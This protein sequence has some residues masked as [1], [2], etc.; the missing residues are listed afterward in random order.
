MK[1]EMAEMG[2]NV[3]IL[4][5]LVPEYNVSAPITFCV[6]LGLAVKHLQDR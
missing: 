6:I 2:Y 4:K 1:Q 5:R 3:P